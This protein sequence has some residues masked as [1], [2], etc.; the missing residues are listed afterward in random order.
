MQ[1][2]FRVPA[3]RI[4]AILSVLAKQCGVPSVCLALQVRDATALGAKVHYL[5]EF[6]I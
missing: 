6:I 1:C 2:V 3:S 4:K 5:V